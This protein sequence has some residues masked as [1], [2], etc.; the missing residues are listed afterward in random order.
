MD[1]TSKFFDITGEVVKRI[2][3]PEQISAK[4]GRPYRINYLIIKWVTGKQGE[5]VD[6]VKIKLME[7]KKMANIRAGY[8]VK[9]PVIYS[10]SIRTDEIQYKIKNVNGVAIEEP[11]LWPEFSVSKNKEIEIINSSNNFETHEKAN[12]TFEDAVMKP[13]LEDDLPF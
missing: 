11:S 7:A 4:T 3:N 12:K 5:Y 10:C 2:H 9:V 6:Y 13:L 1:Q 8:I